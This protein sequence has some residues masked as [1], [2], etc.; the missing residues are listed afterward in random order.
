MSYI[1]NKTDGSVLTT[2]NDGT[3]DNTSDL[4]LVG[5]NYSGY[6][7]Y[8]N[9]NFVHLLEN[10]SNTTAPASP[11]KGQLWYDS[12]NQAIKVYN[13]TGFKIPPAAVS[14]GTAPTNKTIGDLWYDSTNEQL[15]FWDGSVWKIIG[16][17]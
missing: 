15:N 9:E 1:I 2:I 10:F 7:R 14:S 4:I 11:L 12:T 16:P 5:K 8:Q 6:G 13:N 3:V 17:S